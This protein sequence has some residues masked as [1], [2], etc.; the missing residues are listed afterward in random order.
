MSRVMATTISMLNP[1]NSLW[2]GDIFGPDTWL[3]AQPPCPAL[4]VAQ[5]RNSR[6]IS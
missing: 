2:T 4:A 5:A 6:L 1:A 3:V